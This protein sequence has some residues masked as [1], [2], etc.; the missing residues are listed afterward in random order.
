MNR[1]VLAVVAAIGLSMGMLLSVVTYG[2]GGVQWNRE[3]QSV[4]IASASGGGGAFEYHTLLTATAAVSRAQQLLGSVTPYSTT[5]KV[6]TTWNV[7]SWSDNATP[8][9][10]EG[11]DS[12]EMA[13]AAWVV[14]FLANGLTGCHVA[15][16]APCDGTTSIDGVFYV[17]DPGSAALSMAG[18]M[19]TRQFAALDGMTTLSP[20]VV[21]VTPEVL[22]GKTPS[23]P[24]P[25]VIISTPT[26]SPTP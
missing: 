26:P 10:D 20:T 17:L 8:H 16:F 7:I 24:S 21:A 23:A 3:N 2:S 9:P 5:A 15:P 25:F 12:L 1:I 13:E 4:E 6:L 19:T 22:P 14:G 11:V 18:E